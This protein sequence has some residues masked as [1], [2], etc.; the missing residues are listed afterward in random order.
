VS[1]ERDDKAGSDGARNVVLG[2]REFT[3]LPLTL[4]QI[5]AIAK[6]VPKLSNIDA[7]NINDENIDLFVDVLMNGM[8]RS[9]PQ[10]TVDDILDLPMTMMELAQACT[11]VVE[12]AGGRKTV[13]AGEAQATSDSTKS[14]GESSSPSS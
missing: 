4:R 7:A 13:A 6:Q 2:G 10:V 9:Y 3:I 11:V 12:Q 5:R 14:T 8:K 1:L